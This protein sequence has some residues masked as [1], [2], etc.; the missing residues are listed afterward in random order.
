[1]RRTVSCLVVAA[2]ASFGLVS[3]NSAASASTPST[4]GERSKG[5]ARV[6]IAPAM[7]KKL[8][9]SNI[10]VKTIKPAKSR[11]FKGHP[12]AVFPVAKRKKRVV[13]LRGGLFFDKNR[14]HAKVSR[15]RGNYKT[16]RVTGLINGTKRKAVFNTRKSKRPKLGNIRLVLTRYSAGSMNATFNTKRFD[17]GDTFGYAKVRRR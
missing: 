2:V 7:V 12:A 11:K 14:K 6:V 16:G 13:Q 17:R 10:A 9:R 4:E 3:T 15:L 5:K 8:N 1:M